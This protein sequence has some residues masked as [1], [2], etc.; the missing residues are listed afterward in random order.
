MAT[1]EEK[2]SELIR[3]GYLKHEHGIDLL[4]ATAVAMLS[5]VEPERLAEA[6]RIQPDSNGRRSLPPTLY[7]DMKRG[8]KGLMATYDTDDMVEILWHQTHKEQAA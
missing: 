5:D 7:K 3:L 8:V 4:S 6:M 1:Y 2:R